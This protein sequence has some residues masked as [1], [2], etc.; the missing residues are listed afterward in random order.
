MN[1]K[2]QMYHGSQYLNDM[3]LSAPDNHFPTITFGCVPKWLECIFEPYTMRCVPT[4][5][6]FFGVSGD[7][8]QILVPFD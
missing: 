2:T 6:S 7:A 5:Q 4:M 3:Y 8:V 1:A